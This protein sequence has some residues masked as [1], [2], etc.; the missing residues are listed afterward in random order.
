MCGAYGLHN[1]A[2]FCLEDAS[3]A[4][5]NSVRP[6]SIGNLTI[7]RWMEETKKMLSRAGEGWKRVLSFPR[8]LA[9]RRKLS[10]QQAQSLP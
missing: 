3:N 10:P 5:S 9:T 1:C 6:F 4:H 7:A 8:F 2:V